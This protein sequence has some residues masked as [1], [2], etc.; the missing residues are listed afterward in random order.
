MPP[1]RERPGDIVPIAERLLVDVAAE[2][3]LP[4]SPFDDAATSPRTTAPSAPAA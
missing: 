4:S 2:L 1:L 3:G